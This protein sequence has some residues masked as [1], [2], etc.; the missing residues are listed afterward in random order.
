[1]KMLGPHAS[2]NLPFYD[3]TD[4]YAMRHENDHYVNRN[5]AIVIIP[6]KC[7]A[8]AQRMLARPERGPGG[9]RTDW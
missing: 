2:G 9:V 6:T 7:L 5:V 1:M 8:T 3:D 4:A